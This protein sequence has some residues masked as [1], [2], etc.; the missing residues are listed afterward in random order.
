MA[1][2]DALAVQAVADE[3]LYDAGFADGVAS[4][5]SPNGDVTQAQEQLDI[6]AAVAV[7]IQPLNDQI[8]ALQLAKQQE[9]ALLASVQVAAQALVA[10]FPSA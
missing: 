8:S 7:A 9:D 4:V 6:Q 1:K 5:Q 3:A 10:M 2:V